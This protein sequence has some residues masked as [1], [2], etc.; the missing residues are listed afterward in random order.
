[1]SNDSTECLKC[2]DGYKT[3]TGNPKECCLLTEYYNTTSN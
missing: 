3:S 2:A 1:M